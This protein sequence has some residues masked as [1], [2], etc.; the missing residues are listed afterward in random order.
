MVSLLKC[1]NLWLGLWDMTMTK[2]TTLSWE[3]GQVRL[4]WR[5]LNSVK[6]EDF[7]W[8]ERSQEG[9]LRW[10]WEE[11]VRELTGGAFSEEDGPGLGVKTPAVKLLRRKWK[12]RSSTAAGVKALRREKIRQK[13]VT[14][15][16]RAWGG[17]KSKR[18]PSGNSQGEMD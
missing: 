2:K 10:R 6:E 17:R 8:H 5:V 7:Q 4:K 3:R 11:S 14:Y 9:R 18:E 1:Q 12:G 16:P 13:P 15:M